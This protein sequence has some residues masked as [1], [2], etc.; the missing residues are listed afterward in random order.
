[1]KNRVFIP[2]F[3]VIL[4]IT[5]LRYS[6]SKGVKLIQEKLGPNIEIGK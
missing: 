5:T 6:Q 2:A 4:T 3:I 1:M